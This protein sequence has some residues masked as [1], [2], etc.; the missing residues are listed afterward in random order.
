MHEIKKISACAI[1]TH[2]GISEGNVVVTY[3]NLLQH[4]MLH[5]KIYLSGILLDAESK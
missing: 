4:H 3:C 2:L 5:D 1:L